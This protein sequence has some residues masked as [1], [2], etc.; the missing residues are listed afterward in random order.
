MK[1]HPA[2]HVLSEL[3]AP[4]SSIAWVSGQGQILLARSPEG[5]DA[6]LLPM[7]IG[8]VTQYFPLKEGDVALLKDPAV[9]GP[10]RDRLA[11]VQCVSA[12][13]DSRPSVWA[14]TSLRLPGSAEFR[15]P[16]VPLRQKGDTNQMLLQALGDSRHL[17]ETQLNLLD[18]AAARFRH[19]A[20]R[21]LW[22]R[23]GLQD[24][25]QRAK[26]RIR[27]RLEELPEGEVSFD[28]ATGGEQIRLRLQNDGR[29]LRFDF[30]GTSPGR[31]LFLP[32]A[33]TSGLV[34]TTVREWLQWEME[35]D[36]ACDHLIPLTVPNGC[37]LNAQTR[38]A[39][40]GCLVEAAAWLKTAVEG[41]LHRWDRR[42]PRALTNYFDLWSELKFE[43]HPPE[44]VHLPSGSPAREGA[45]GTSFWQQRPDHGDCSV[46]DLE[47]RLPVRVLRAVE[48]PPSGHKA[49]LNGGRGLL[50]Q[51][52]ILA[53]GQIIHAASPSRW[54]AEKHQLP[55][56]AP[57]VSLQR[58]GQD[59]RPAANEWI[60]LQAGDVLT[61]HSGS[62]GSL[63]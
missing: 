56:D 62:G 33:A 20:F 45:E 4:F 18:G 50:L 36:S 21:D 12:E 17:L 63:L 27:R 61:L 2:Q 19:E 53:P 23:R 37:F 9:G 35:L 29:A 34:R 24:I 32:L 26:E 15:L 51:L 54:P 40:S 44:A 1:C 22:S 46:E 13:S 30:T 58:A 25:E 6:G 39:C 38:D 41:A 60:P 48:R 57:G 52:E 11:L 28:L 31:R 42:Q 55:G 8:A 14:A 43:G 5:L 47:R 49:R 16:P 10:G 3:S 7:G 59:S